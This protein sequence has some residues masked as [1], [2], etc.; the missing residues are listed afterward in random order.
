MDL[1]VKIKE[2]GKCISAMDEKGFQSFVNE[3]QYATAFHDIGFAAAQQ[4]I[5]GADN[6]EIAESRGAFNGD[7]YHPKRRDEIIGSP[8]YGM[9]RR[10][11]R[12]RFSLS[13]QEIPDNFTG[14]LGLNQQKVES[15]KSALNV[16]FSQKYGGLIEEVTNKKADRA[17]ETIQKYGLRG[18]FTCEGNLLDIFLENYRG[19]QL[20][21]AQKYAKRE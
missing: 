17:R 19:Q 15:I 3:L 21:I 1:E 7:E 13:E 8:L 18:I 14:W 10:E 5:R 4:G 16:I 11:L 9:V 6:A 12:K 20:P 2:A